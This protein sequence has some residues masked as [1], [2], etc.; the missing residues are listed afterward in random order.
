MSKAEGKTSTDCG[1]RPRDRTLAA[2]AG[3]DPSAYAGAVNTPV[4]RASTIVFPTLA[5]F[6]QS[7]KTLPGDAVTYGVHGTPSTF[8]L[9]EAVA[10]LEG[11]HR[12]RLAPSGLM[13]VSGP[14]LSV[15]KPGD[16]LLVADSVYQPTRMFCHG[17][18]QR[19][20]VRTEFY[21]P[22]IGEGIRELLRPDTRAVFLESP[23]SQT[24]EMQDVP[25][26]ARI[27]REAGVTTML[28]STW[29]SP[30]FCKPLAL[31][32]DLSIHAGTKYIAGH[33]DLLIGTVTAT[34]AAYPAIRDGW[35]Q[36]GIC[37][38]PDDA[39]LTLRGLRSMP[40]RM[41]MQQESAL[42][43]AAW[44][45]GR[46]EVEAVLYPA[47]AGD[48]GHDIWK[49]DCRGASSLFGFALRPELSGSEAALAAM[50]DSMK[51]FALGFSWGGFESLLI[52][53]HPDRIRTAAPWPRPGGPAGQ[54]LRIHV[55]L[56][57]PQD[58]IEDLDA[59]F[60]RL[61]AALAR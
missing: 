26:I 3:R 6:R 37:V 57:D 17:M 12:T 32:V 61:R 54:L 7:R 53:T 11:G 60:A 28:D 14:L 25:A 51:L 15:L 52:P 34:E 22:L 30:L 33:S 55:G 29:A 58:L 35:N 5:A 59:G 44:L 43:V 21:D 19:L 39:Y 8:A 56:E 13:A 16:H 24:F 50:F 2:H 40:A 20:G 45:R 31:G 46:P 9:E 23:G 1:R 18:L 41:A 10:R 48:P 42:Q 4:H 38:S 36:M 47:L 27:A 49:R